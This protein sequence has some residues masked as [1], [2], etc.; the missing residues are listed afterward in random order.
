MRNIRKWLSVLLILAMTLTVLPPAS[1]LAAE[2][3][4]SCG[5]PL[6]WELDLDRGELTI[7]GTG[8]MDSWS[9]GPNPWYE[10][11][12]WVRKVTIADGV[13]NIGDYAFAFCEHIEDIDIPGSVQ[14]IGEHAFAGCVSLKT[15]S[16]PAGITEIEPSAFSEC[17]SLKSVSIP[18]G[19]ETIGQFAFTSCDSLKEVAVPD[20]VKTIGPYALSYCGVTEIR[21]PGSVESIGHYAF[22]NDHALR[23]AEVADGVG[24]I[25]ESAFFNCENLEKVTILDRDCGIYDKADTLGDPAK[26]I[27]RGYKGSTAETYANRY[28]YK[29]ESMQFVDKPGFPAAVQEQ[30]WTAYYE[31]I[32][33]YP[34]IQP[35]D[36]FISRHYGCFNGWHVVLMENWRMVKLDAILD[37]DIGGFVFRFPSISDRELFLAWKDGQL[38]TV[39]DAYDQGLLT[40]GDISELYRAFGGNKPGYDDQAS[41]FIDVLD[42]TKYYYDAVYWAYNSEPRIVFGMDMNYFGP[43]GACTR[44]HVVTFLWRAA[45]CP[46]PENAETPFKDLKKGAFYEKAVAWAVENN[47]TNGLSSEKF[48]PD[49]TCTR[50]QIVTFLWRAAGCP[51]PKNTETP[52]KDLKKD[53]FYEK[54]VAWAVGNEITNGLKPTVFEPDGTCTRGQVVT[55]LYRDL[56]K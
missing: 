7:S 16:I 27:I 22:S 36:V 56:A 23:Y 28:G 17:S 39:T 46:E 11:Q 50:G 10:L 15:V 19:V 42:P 29:F 18:A 38:L 52:F 30:I 13:P 49:A 54:A 21:V 33:E 45:G 35:E 1:T 31:T 24:E 12:E 2:T 32:R 34:D 47:I 4:G 48:G 51:E 43:D 41:Y 44:G 20:T 8:R 26:T 5:Y 37:L 40:D 25:R 9:L 3:S 6:E 14:E 53:A 55:F